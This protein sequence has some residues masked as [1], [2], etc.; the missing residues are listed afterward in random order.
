MTLDELR[1]RFLQTSFCP[2]RLIRGREETPV[3]YTELKVIHDP[4][5]HDSYSSNSMY[6]VLVYMDGE[7]HEAERPFADWTTS[8]DAEFIRDV[9]NWFRKD[10]GDE[11]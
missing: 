3:C 11:Q 5:T 6:N 4:A 9:V 8:A 2:S 1:E 7:R 10:M